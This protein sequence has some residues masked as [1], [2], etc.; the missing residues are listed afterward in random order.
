MFVTEGKKVFRRRHTSCQGGDAAS[1]VGLAKNK[2]EGSIST[3]RT[4]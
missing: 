1:V 2:I 4:N 3:A